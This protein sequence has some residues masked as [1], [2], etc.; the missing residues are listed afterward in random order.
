M[1]GRDVASNGQ[2]GDIFGSAVSGSETVTDDGLPLPAYQPSVPEFDPHKDA[3]DTSEAAPED[4][5][6]PVAP[7]LGTPS[8]ETMIRL[9]NAARKVTGAASAQ[10]PVVAQA[11]ATGGVR[12]PNFG[13]GSLIGRMTGQGVDTPSERA[14]PSMHES[15]PQ[16]PN[17]APH[18]HQTAPQSGADSEQDKIEIPAFLRRQAN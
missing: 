3:R 2:I 17:V 12:K 6:A 5:V 10:K 8:A 15:V 9:E 13:I 7:P 14:V 4:F 16:T 1:D 18:T 11:Q